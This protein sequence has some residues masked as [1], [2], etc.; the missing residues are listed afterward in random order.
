MHPGRNLAGCAELGF[1]LGLSRDSA[2][3]AAVAVRDRPARRGGGSELERALLRRSVDAIGAGC[4]RCERCRRTPLIGERV[5]VRESGAVVCE[6]CRTV[7]GRPVDSRIVHS[8]EFG[9]AV[10]IRIT[11]QRGAA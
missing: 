4:E 9:H 2:R 10:R 3:A 6:L 11:D 5:Y 7:D 8:S 1:M